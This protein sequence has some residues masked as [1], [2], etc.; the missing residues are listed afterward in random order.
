[1]MSRQAPGPHQ[2]F[3][4]QTRP[5]AH[6]PGGFSRFSQEIPSVSALHAPPPSRLAS[7]IVGI[8]RPRSLRSPGPPKPATCTGLGAT[9]YCC[10][11]LQERSASLPAQVPPRSPRHLPAAVASSS[12]RPRY[13]SSGRPRAVRPLRASMK[14]PL[15]GLASVAAPFPAQPSWAMAQ[16]A[17][18]GMEISLHFIS[19]TCPLPN[20]GFFNTTI[21]QQKGTNSQ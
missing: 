13:A 19:L 14:G 11:P 2:N 16:I 1:M 21:L 5:S 3:F 15:C 8:H 6:L 17:L 9:G 10:T 18:Q 4:H 20:L 7:F 12:K